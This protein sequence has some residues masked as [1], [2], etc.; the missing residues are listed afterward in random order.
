MYFEY[1]PQRTCVMSGSVTFD[2]ESKKKIVIA[3]GR[4]FI[5]KLVLQFHQ[6][7]IIKFFHHYS[8]CTRK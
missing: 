8:T 1:T 3:V 6:A 2:T 4:K 5:S 7:L